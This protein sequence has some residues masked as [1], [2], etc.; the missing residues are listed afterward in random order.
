[1][2]I[3]FSFIDWL[4][5]FI[6][7]AITFIKQLWHIVTTVPPIIWTLLTSA[8]MVLQIFFELFLTV[9]IILFIWRLIP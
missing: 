5:T 2:S 4:S 1:M 3:I 8:P 7:G 9:A 6:E